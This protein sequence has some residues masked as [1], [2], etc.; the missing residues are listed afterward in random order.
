VELLP[1]T[2]NDPVDDSALSIKHLQSCWEPRRSKRLA[3]GAKRP[4]TIDPLTQAICSTHEWGLEEL[5]LFG[6]HYFDVKLYMDWPSY[7]CKLCPLTTGANDVANLRLG[8][9][10]FSRGEHLKRGLPPNHVLE[11]GDVLAG[12]RT[13]TATGAMGSHLAM[14]ILRLC[15][16]V[17]ATLLP[18]PQSTPYKVR[19]GS[20]QFESIPSV[21][22]HIRP[23]FE[24]KCTPSLIVL[25][26]NKG[27]EN[28]RF[29]IA[30]EMLATA[31]C[32]YLSASA[33]AP[34]TVFAVR[35]LGSRFT[36]YRAEFPAKYLE[37]VKE[38][39][40]GGDIVI[41]R[42]GG[43]DSDDDNGLRLENPHVRRLILTFLTSMMAACG[44]IAQAKRDGVV[45][46]LTDDRLAKLYTDIK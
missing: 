12:T 17:P 42:L 8:S 15:N 35:V 13:E 6:L 34:R 21:V 38:G 46:A 22:V 44:E 4:K 30:G 25:T 40:P 28:G 24:E 14:C 9:C 23:S 36:F 19:V 32:A 31:M 10:S 41:F 18:L 26:E 45:P 39:N 37:S 20:R 27:S 7:F 29:H 5:L 11:F 2:F 3:K 33:P 1:L 16:P 43:K